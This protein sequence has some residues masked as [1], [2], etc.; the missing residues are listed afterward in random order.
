MKTESFNIEISST[1][2]KAMVAMYHDKPLAVV[3]ELLTNAWDS[4]KRAG[5]TSVPIDVHLFQ[6]GSPKRFVVRDYGTGI[7]PERMKDFCTVYRSDKRDDDEQTGFFGIGSKVPFSISDNFTVTTYYNGMKYSYLM[8]LTE[9]LPVYTLIAEQET[10]E[11]NGVEVSVPVHTEELEEQ[12]IKAFGEFY[13]LSDMEIRPISLIEFEKLEPEYINKNIEIYLSNQIDISHLSHPII[14]NYK[15]NFY[16]YKDIRQNYNDADYNINDDKIKYVF[17]K[18]L[19]ALNSKYG[20]YRAVIDIPDNVKLDIA[21]DREYLEINDRNTRILYDIVKQT[22]LN[23]IKPEEFEVVYENYNNNNNIIKINN[24]LFYLLYPDQSQFFVYGEEGLYSFYDKVSCY[25]VNRLYETW[26]WVSIEKNELL[27]GKF[28]S[29]IHAFVYDNYGSNTYHY[30]R[31]AKKAIKLGYGNNSDNSVILISDEDFKKLEACFSIWGITDI[32]LIGH[33]ASELLPQ[34]RQSTRLCTGNTKIDT[35]FRY[36][37]NGKF[38][39]NSGDYIARTLSEIKQSI[40]KITLIVTTDERSFAWNVPNNLLEVFNTIRK[41]RKFVNPYYYFKLEKIFKET[42]GFSIQALDSV[43][44]IPL[45]QKDDEDVNEAIKEYIFKDMNPYTLSHNVVDYSKVEDFSQRIYNFFVSDIFHV[46]NRED[47]SF[48]ICPSE[49]PA[50]PIAYNNGAIGR[51]YTKLSKRPPTTHLGKKLYGALND[52]IIYAENIW[53]KSHLYGNTKY[54]IDLKK[55]YAD[56]YKNANPVLI[57]NLHEQMQK[58][59]KVIDSIVN[60]KLSYHESNKYRA[61]RVL[62]KCYKYNPLNNRRW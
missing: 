46:P 5:H 51:L 50:Y 24:K 42:F 17:S 40:D 19:Y 22:F 16:T 10:N 54:A 6:S 60:Y 29:K 13:K 41:R 47:F 56:G 18:Y 15:H 36:A 48:G 62:K 28:G 27:N 31:F 39:I 9:T 44:F 3:R 26:N 37:N 32:E 55:E 21:P 38:K 12:L 61:D 45:G 57:K 2:I 23:C 4:H 8:N 7:S 49:A 20:T 1:A 33:V 11:F 35:M 25:K 34:K 43:A 30:K 53:F 14:F 58:S 52:V 59:K